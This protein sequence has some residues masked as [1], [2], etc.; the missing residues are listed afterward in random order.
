MSP[1]CP[2][3]A[4]SIVPGSAEGPVVAMVEGLSFWGGVDAA[5]GRPFHFRAWTPGDPLAAGP[6]APYPR[7]GPMV[8]PHVVLVGLAGFDGGNYRLCDEPAR[9]GRLLAAAPEAYAVGV[10]LELM[11]LETVEPLAGERPL[12]LVVTEA[13]AFPPG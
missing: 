9:S 12:D 6:S 1:D 13:G 10:G 7:D 2:A 11:R 4:H 8:Q 3:T 5:D